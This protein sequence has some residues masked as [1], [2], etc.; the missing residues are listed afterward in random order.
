MK[1]VLKVFAFVVTFA[2][3]VWLAGWIWFASIIP[4][5]VTE[6]DYAQLEKTDAIVVLTGS[7]GRIET[8]LKLLQNE[9]AAR[10]FISGAG[11]KVSIADL[12]PDEVEQIAG[13][14]DAITLGHEATD[15]PGNAIETAA[16]A[17]REQIRSI[18]VVTAA[19]HMPRS[20]LE[21]EAAMPD[22]TIIPHPVF[23]ER[24]KADWWRWPGT[25]NLIAREYTKYILTWLRIELDEAVRA[26]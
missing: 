7:P 25:A 17:R 11:A 22:V 4:F 24:V 26:L 1:R 8:G 23:S 16:W 5:P 12:V 13:I 19:Y 6:P 10:L 14:E 9:A 18:R 20:L 3:L 21:L 2:V 15:T